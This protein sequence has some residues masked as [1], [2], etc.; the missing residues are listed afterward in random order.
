M[1]EMA[2]ERARQA[3]VQAAAAPGTRDGSRIVRGRVTAAADGL[4]TVAEVLQGGGAGPSH[5][6]VVAWGGA[7]LEVG[8]LVWLVWEGARTRPTILSAA[9]GAASTPEAGSVV[10]LQVGVPYVSGSG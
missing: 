10:V 9:A 5:A 2:Q 3:S 7:T 1:D 6:R 4:H 8:A